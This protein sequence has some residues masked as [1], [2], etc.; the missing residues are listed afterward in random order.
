MGNPKGLSSAEAKRLLEKFGPNSLAEKKRRPLW[1]LFLDQFQ[2]TMIIVL[3]IAAI[4]SYLL[5]EATD[6]F[7]II[8]IVLLN[9]VLGFV[10]E[11]KAE[12]AFKAL[13]AMLTQNARV[14]RDGK[15]KSIDVK[16][17]VPGDLV[18]LEAGD[19][20]PADGVFVEGFS[21]ACDEAMLTGE[22]VPVHKK[23]DDRVFM[24]T[25]CLSG[26]GHIL[27]DKTGAATEMGRVAELVQE[28]EDERTPLEVDFEKLGK[29]IAIGVL[30]LC[31]F[32][33]VAGVLHG[34]EIFE[35][36]ITSISLAVAAIPEGL[37]AV[38]T[39][40]LA[41][42]VQRMAKRKALIRKL[43]AVETLGCTTVIATD[44][45][46]TLTRNEMVVKKIYVNNRLIDVDGIG[47]TPK[48]NFYEKGKKI[49]IGKDEELLLR[50]GLL[51]NSSYLRD[52]EKKGW[53]II[54]DSTEGA[55]V[56][57]AAKADMWKDDASKNFPEVAVFPFDSERKRMT[58]IHKIEKGRVAYSKGAPESIISVSS[59]IL[60]NS[61]KVKLTQKDKEEVLNLANS[62]ASDGYRVLAFAYREI[63]HI[64]L[65]ADKVEKDL[66]FIGLAAMIDAPRQEV[67][68]AVA[69]CKSAGIKVIMITGDHPLT[70]KNIAAYLGFFNGKMMTG[71]QLDKIGED[72]LLSIVDEVS[73]YARVN[74]THK[75]RIVEALKRKGHVVAVTGDGVNDAPALKK[76]DIGIAMGITGT[77]VSKE[78]A[79]MVLNDDNFSTIVAA[80]EEGRGVY[81]NIKKTIAYLFSGNIAEVAIIFFA[82]MLGFPLPLLAF[83]ILWINLITD[84]LPALALAVEPIEKDVMK[85][86]PRSR[87]ESVW[88]D[89]YLFIVEAPLLL[90][91]MCL[92]I[93]FFELTYVNDLVRAQTMVFTMLIMGE[94]LLAFSVR[95]LN[96]TVINDL[97]S[98]KW[99][100]LLVIVTTLIHCAI[101]YVEDLSHIFKVV[102]LTLFDW[103]LIFVFSFILFSYIELR[104]WLSYKK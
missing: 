27:V 25:T 78:S 2:D 44:K 35:M 46:G 41:V 36:F 60:K 32:I 39:I 33:F 69:M 58:T 97:F 96:K 89:T 22:S 100:V 85:R 15:L 43:K 47:Y 34:F 63:D 80:V 40:I 64:E 66:V 26:K 81:D 10:Q 8:F 57:L 1:K 23:K 65:S 28:V 77:D 30:V 19:R 37:P 4:I 72:E 11:Y 31:F 70:A 45:T 71:E 48:G 67:K 56:V 49:T 75:L 53:H 104:K 51:C 82:I 83:Q 98:N 79:D 91:A 94:K 17:I 14:W 16:E 103:G 93:F 92:G 76:A 24:G 42:G 6:A 9:G 59:F 21:F 29:S 61:K 50:I 90:T 52:D 5:G 101:L 68:D 88:K 87:N 73:V 20:V 55:L 3:I 74:P 62:F 95:H 102:P 99:L 38:L 7:L 54:G 13:K 18:L 84:G 12:Q 86:K